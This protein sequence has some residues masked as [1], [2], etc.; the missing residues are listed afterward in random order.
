M[1]TPPGTEIFQEGEHQMLALVAAKAVHEE[2]AV[3][4]QRAAEAI[5]RC[6]GELDDEEREA[7]ARRIDIVLYYQH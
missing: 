5:A 1:K 3:A 2:K 6:W 7:H 4:L